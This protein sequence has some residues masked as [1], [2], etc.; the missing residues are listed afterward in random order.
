MVYRSLPLIMT[1][2]HT[3]IRPAMTAIAAVLAFSSAPLFA[4]SVDP[5]VATPA[6]ALD[7]I[8]VPIAAEP[9]AAEPIVEG[10]AVDPLAAE[11]VAK[12]AA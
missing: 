12:P 3:I 11:A 1:H 2:R 9:P 6:P 7:V 10:T 8:S 5:V 4:Q